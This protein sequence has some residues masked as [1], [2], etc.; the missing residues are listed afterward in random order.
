MK[1]DMKKS[2]AKTLC[3]V[4]ALSLLTLVSCTKPKAGQDDTT[5][6]QTTKAASGS[7][8]DT[9]DASTAQTEDTT[10]QET[11]PYTYTTVT[12]ESVIDKKTQS[13]KVLKYPEF[14]GFDD[15]AK[16]KALN[17][18]IAQIC[19]FKY[20][21]AIPN[22]NELLKEEAY[23]G[24]KA[25]DVKVTLITE[26]LVSICISGSLRIDIPFKDSSDRGFFYTINIS[27]DNMKALSS[28]DV[29]KD[30]NG[31]ISKF[32]NGAFK[33]VGG[34][35]NIT[36]QVTLTDLITQYRT[37]Y[38]IYPEVY[39]TKG[40]LCINTEVAPALGGNAQFSI[41]LADVSS[42]I[43]TGDPGIAMLVSNA[44]R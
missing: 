6:A 7:T 40:T 22:L 2:A 42:Y 9:T 41:S 12:K 16:E 43:N 34:M 11:L 33:Q 29:F 23:I 30:F 36:N 37:E 14:D 18:L 35:E 24:Y 26:K 10:A 3:I 44:S 20:S 17:E 38:Q 1:F 15:A 31:I 28:S 8:A 19:E 13:D 25:V 21:A 32:K 39:F 5:S 4:I 27:L